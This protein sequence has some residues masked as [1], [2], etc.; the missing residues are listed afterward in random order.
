[1]DF[2]GAFVQIANG[3]KTVIGMVDKLAG[4]IETSRERQ[5]LKSVLHQHQ[6][7]SF[8]LNVYFR[9]DLVEKLD[10]GRTLTY[11]DICANI[12]QMIFIRRGIVMSIEDALKAKKGDDINF[13]AISLEFH[14]LS[15]TLERLIKGFYI[16]LSAMKD[17]KFVV[18]PGDINKMFAETL[19]ATAQL[20]RFYPNN[21]SE[22]E[23]LLSNKKNRQQLASFAKEMEE[24][25][26]YLCSMRL[27]S[28]DT[29]KR[30]S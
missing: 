19:A 6:E 24:T 8:D 25:V 5:R 27:S 3:F 12:F 28:A 30:P 20:K 14:E 11:A 2:A 13:Y 26:E 1:M 9:G 16:I 4:L 15:E 23:K 17:D 29:S 7:A 18:I 21:Y 22:L 10:A